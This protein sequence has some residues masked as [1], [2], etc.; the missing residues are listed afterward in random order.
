VAFHWLLAALLM[1]L[2]ALGLYM[3]GLPDAGFD[4]KKIKLILYH[5][6]LGG[7]LL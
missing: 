5:K 4:T 1:G 2:I 6:E 3:V 7:S